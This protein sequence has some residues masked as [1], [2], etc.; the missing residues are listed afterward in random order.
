MG[1]GVLE[2]EAFEYA[3]D[4]IHAYQDAGWERP[5]ASR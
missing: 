5:R 2:D 4:G 1:F 3:D